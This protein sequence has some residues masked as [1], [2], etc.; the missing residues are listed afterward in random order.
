MSKQST[1]TSSEQRSYSVDEMMARLREGE[2]EKREQDEGELVTRPDGTQVLRVRRRKR[3]SKQPEAE[4]RK[5]SIRPRNLLLPLVIAVIVLLGV[6]AGLLV[7]KYNSKGF[8]EAL[9]KGLGERTGS[10]MSIERLAVTPVRVRAQTVRSEWQDGGMLEGMELSELKADLKWTSF[11]NGSLEG[12]RIEAARGTLQVG[13]GQPGGSPRTAPPGQGMISYDELRCTDL[14]IRFGDENSHGALLKGT[15]ATL[16][17]PADGPTQVL[18]RGGEL[19]LAGW[20]PMEVDLGT[21]QMTS[22]GFEIVSLQVVPPGGD[23]GMKLS[24][25]EA[26]QP[27]RP[28]QMKLELTS[29]P[30]EA[31]VGSGFG[32]IFS[33]LVDSNEG[34]MVFGNDGRTGVDVRI[35]F[36]GKSGQ[37]VGLPV[38]D[39]LKTLLADTDFVRPEF[40]SIRGVFH[41]TP[42]GARLQDLDCESKSQFRVRG[43]LELGPED[44][45]SGT[46]EI[47]IAEEK[48]ITSTGRKR[49]GVFGDPRDG[50]CWVTVTV[51]GDTNQPNDNF[52]ILLQKSAREAYDRRE[53]NSGEDRFD[54]LTQPR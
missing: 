20:N 14:T 15:E 21:G 23:G 33:G 25:F 13:P 31:V 48:I 3:R 26:V 36:S 28:V 11:L 1:D 27:G 52:K 49:N 7:A 44:E 54:E 22:G 45:L 38:L 46:L 40:G 35:D 6:G 16:V 5:R 41:M 12:R 37:M 29:F 24:T 8:Q 34:T 43:F 30:L 17:T 9:E 42:S 10:R 4:A 53:G 39:N 18:L 51:S 32:R 47:G 50:Y 2:R 19:T